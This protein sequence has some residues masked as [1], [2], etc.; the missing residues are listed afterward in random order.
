MP[1]SKKI[2]KDWK[3]KVNKLFKSNVKNK[4]SQ[5]YGVVSRFGTGWKPYVRPY[6]GTAD[7]D[8]AKCVSL[9]LH[10]DP[11][12][13]TGP[14]GETRD[15][16][17][18]DPPEPKITYSAFGAVLSSIFTKKK[19]E[20]KTERKYREVSTKKLPPP[21]GDL[22]IQTEMR[23]IRWGTSPSTV[24]AIETNKDLDAA[25]I[26]AVKLLLEYKLIRLQEEDY[27]LAEELGIKAKVPDAIADIEI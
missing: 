16:A 20:D 17:Q 27:K 2:V 21:P 24:G 19:I 4:H 10:E 23:D 6:F 7:F 11:Q 5:Q 9:D 25:R 1:K 8:L 18:L 13:L 12:Y 22:F 26:D 14:F 3:P 15:E